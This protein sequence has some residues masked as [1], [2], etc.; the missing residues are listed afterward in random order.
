MTFYL[1]EGAKK[2]I[3]TLES[4]GF[5]AYIVG[6]CVRDL[7]RGVKPQDYDICTSAAPD[8]VTGLFPHTVATGLKHG[9]VTVIEDKTPFEVTTFRT[10]GEYKDSRHPENVRFVRN[11][12]D[13]LARRDFTVNAMCYNEKRGL[14]DCFG[15]AADIKAKILRAVGDAD[16]RFNE[17]AL[18]I[19]R[20]FRFACTLDFSIEEKTFAAAIKN[21][22]L[23]KNVS[24][25][26]VREE[27]T[28][29]ACGKSPEAVLPLLSTGALPHLTANGKIA[30]IADLPPNSELKFFAL[31]NL[32]GEN[33]TDAAKNLKCP[34]AFKDYCERMEAGLTAKCETPA[35]IKRLLRLLEGDIFDLFAYKREIG[36]E[37]T[38]SA[39]A[40]AESIIASGEPY[41]ISQ[42]KIGGSDIAKKGC[43]GRE[44]GET[45]EKIL[46][47]VIADPSLNRKEIL[48]KLI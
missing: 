39:V 21:A 9:T 24:R 22:N 45:L 23:L 8:A 28:R 31:L 14:I 15:G 34:N 13:D 33:A 32:T 35:D 5:E 27:L 36:G 44:I 30:K 7:I 26:R 16:S 12:E 41:K 47:K 18:R 19:L 42:L 4:S 38:A 2:I 37:D 29:L 43:R 40:T 46:E 17:D 10:D 3:E 11:V 20:L 6:G 25:E 48:E 1:P